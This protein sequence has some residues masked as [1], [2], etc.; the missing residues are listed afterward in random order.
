MK[1]S[2]LEII[3]DELFPNKNALR[4]DRTGLQ[5]N[6]GDFDISSIH[7]AYEL[8]QEVIDECIDS[9]SQMLI[10]FHPLIYRMLKTID[11]ND[12]VGELI[13]KLIKNNISLF[14][15][16]TIYDTNPKGTNY[17]IA[18][19]FGLKKISNL[20]DIFPEGDIGMGYIGE[21][22]NEISLIDLLDKCKSIFGS[23]IRY[24]KG[25]NDKVKRIAIVGGSGSSFADNV[26]DSEIDAYITAD[27]SYHTFHRFNG[28]ISLIDPGHYEMERF[29][30]EGMSN[31]L[32]QS[33]LLTDIRISSS[34]LNTNP[35]NYYV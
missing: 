11:V 8:N 21:F 4:D 28:K 35:I 30:V 13:V 14:A 12:R 9:G 27:N 6:C 22:E 7:I 25:T 33:S 23:P 18:E 17:L 3:L 32:M 29:V 5:V 24:T 16:H 26:F 19:K 31:Y 20:V 10:V 2:Q 1:L 34:K 15:V